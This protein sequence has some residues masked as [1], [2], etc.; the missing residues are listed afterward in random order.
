MVSLGHI[1]CSTLECVTEQ[2]PS[3][4]DERMLVLGVGM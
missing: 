4:V 2:N 1:I 3:L